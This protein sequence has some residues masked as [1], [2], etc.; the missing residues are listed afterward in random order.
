MMRRPARSTLFPYTTLFRS[1][2]FC[3]DDGEA[4]SRGQLRVQRIV[5]I[6]VGNDGRNRVGAGTLILARRPGDD[7]VGADAQSNRIGNE[8]VSRPVTIAFRI[9]CSA[10]AT[11]A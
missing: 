1:V 8:H 2:H 10:S 11:K 9:P 5:G 3:D 6:A 4:V 7:A